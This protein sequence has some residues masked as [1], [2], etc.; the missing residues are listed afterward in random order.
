MDKEIQKAIEA[1]E[2]N[3]AAMELVRNWC[4][5]A[6]VEK[7]GGTG[8][9]EQ[10]TGLPIGHHGLKCDYATAGGMFTWDL[11]DAALDFYDRNCIDCKH[12]KPVSIPNLLSLVKERD[13]RRAEEAKEA[14]A[15]EA[16]RLEIQNSRKLA[17]S[18]LR[19]GLGSVSSA[20]VDHIDEYD[21]HRDQEHRD[22]LCESARLAP[23]HFTQPIVDYIFDLAERETWFAEAGLTVL[24]HLKADPARIVRIALTSLAQTRPTETIGRV[25]LSRLSM[26]DA[27]LVTEALP[28][29]IERAKP[30][31][32]YGF[33]RAMPEPEPELLLALWTTHQAAVRAGLDRLLSSRHTYQVELAARGLLVLQQSDPRAMHGFLRT[34]ISKFSRAELLLD[35]FDEHHKAFRHLRDALAVAFADF[36][37]EVDTL[38]QEFI[39]TSDRNTKDR[40]YK[41]YE[42]PLRGHR[43]DE[44]PISPDSRVHRICFQRLLWASTTEES[45]EILQCAREVFRG[46]PYEMI[47]IARAELDGLLGAILLLDD[48]LRRHDETPAPKE[49]NVLKLMERNNRRS[50]ITYLITS[51][52]EWASIAAKDDPVLVKKVIGL[53]DQ[54]PD[55]RDHLKGMMLA[56]IA[57]IGD[58]VEGLNLVLPHLYS[59][60][61]GNSVAVR[62]YAAAALGKAPQ[63]NIPP[64]VYEAFSVLLWDQYVAVHKAAVRALGYFQLPESLRNRAAQALLNLIRHYSQKSGED[65]FLVDCVERLAYEL[66]GVGNTAG[67]VGQY[68]IKVLLGVEQLYLTNHLSS[69]GRILYGTE[70]FIDLLIKLIPDS[71]DRDHRSDE[72]DLLAELPNEVILSR[73][74]ELAKLGMDIGLDRPWLAL[75]IIEALGRAGALAEARRIAEAG[76]NRPDATVHNQWHRIMMK[77][78]E[79]IAA[80]EEAVAEGRTGDLEALARQWEE[81]AQRYKEF[82][83]DVQKRNSRSSFSRPL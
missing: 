48:R 79:I 25:L 17:R 4:A 82:Q 66:R 52:V 58:T 40:A 77:S 43:H 44:P 45:E 8:L 46:R 71:D 19:V 33:G 16:R 41:I 14:T 27:A 11:Q 62:A 61:V 13:E 69:L 10:A 49:Q 12:R 74:A 59:G 3:R 55:G 38:V 76:V 42:A 23:E 57:H 18:Q 34:M 68:L 53:F 9:V 78:V 15:A 26:A 35:D 63:E 31:N 7:H 70:G 47:D 28:N 29:I 60:L 24:D 83:A 22:R 32:E 1:G 37:D 20:I 5:H 67:E 75:H 6:K 39:T 56:C 65:D 72:L 50:S 51:L 54:I 2:R 73:K 80:F 21:E 30:Y 81:N 64:L 36:P